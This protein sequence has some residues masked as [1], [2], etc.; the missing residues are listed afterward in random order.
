MLLVNKRGNH[1]NPIL[2]QITSEVLLGLVAEDVE[3]LAI[4]HC[5]ECRVFS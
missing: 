4:L 3:F 2:S 5:E 1:G